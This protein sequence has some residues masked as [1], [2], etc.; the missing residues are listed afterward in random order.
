MKTAFKIAFIYALS[1]ILWIWL[2]DEL[3]LVFNVDSHD[4]MQ[5]NFY[6]TLKGIFYVAFT[7]LLL[8]FLVYSY[9][10]NLNEKIKCLEIVNHQLEQSNSELE[11]YAYIASHDL[12][13]PLRVTSSLLQRLQLKYGDQLDE[14]A[15]KYI[16]LS[17]E[18]AK[19]MR[20]F[21]QDLLEFSKVGNEKETA[22]FVDLNEL[23]DE[24]K[25]DLQK[26]ISEEKA[27]VTADHL[28]VVYC[29]RMKMKQVLCNLISNAIKYRHPGIPPRVFIKGI[30]EL[31][32][33]KIQVMDNGIGIDGS[34]HDRIFEL[35][36]R[37]HADSSYTGT[38]IGLTIAKKIVEKW[39]GKIGLQSEPGAGSTFFFTL[40]VN[41]PTR[42]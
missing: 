17:I 41:L 5:M 6:Q 25:L 39:N 9:H 4:M 15:N 40:P 13:E 7:A 16:E 2:S 30:R 18:N 24:I 42:S 22:A 3:L 35:F 34:F 11:Q 32:Y 29:E 12:Q 26:T 1:G 14:K 27:I 19:R 38:G 37:L 21:V 8:F 36:Q 10:R 33:W 28:P 31:N 23:L 20:T